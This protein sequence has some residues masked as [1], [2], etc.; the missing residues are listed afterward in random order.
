MAKEEVAEW[1]RHG[2]ARDPTFLVP[3]SG[4]LNAA[5]AC[6]LHCPSFSVSDPNTRVTADESNVCI[7]QVLDIGFSPEKCLLYD[8]LTRREAVDGL[9]FYPREIL[10]I[11]ESFTFNLRKHMTAIVDICWGACVRKRMLQT[12]RLTPLRL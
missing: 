6:H 11:H 3:P 10:H 12:C 4:P 8:H 5:L 2:V 1:E 7:K 9:Q